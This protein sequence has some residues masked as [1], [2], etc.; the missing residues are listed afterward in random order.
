MLVDTFFQLV[1]II[2]RISHEAFEAFQKLYEFDNTNSWYNI[3]VSWL[4]SYDFD[5]NYTQVKWINPLE[6]L[7]SKMLYYKKHFMHFSE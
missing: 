7:P 1:V 2:N 6:P 5:I 4:F 3:V